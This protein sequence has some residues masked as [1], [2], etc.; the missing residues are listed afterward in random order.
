MGFRDGLKE[1]LSKTSRNVPPEQPP[2]GGTMATGEPAA[3]GEHSSSDRDLIL[4]LT[5]SLQE[6]DVARKLA[7]AESRNMASA[8]RKS[9]IDSVM[10]DGRQHA[11]SYKL[12]E[13]NCL[14]YDDIIPDGFYDVWGDFADVVPTGG[15]FPSLHDLRGIPRIT[16]DPREVLL[17]DHSADPGLCTAAERL[18]ERLS[19][20][21]SVTDKI[22][23][24]VSWVC[25]GGDNDDHVPC[26]YMYNHTR[27]QAIAEV[28]SSALGGS[29]STTKELYKQWEQ[30]SRDVK[31]RHRGIVVPLGELS[32]GLYRHRALLFKVLAD[33]IELPCR[34]VR[35][36]HNVPPGGVLKA[37]ALV[38]VDGREMMVDLLRSPGRIVAFAVN[39]LTKLLGVICIAV[40]LMPA[41]LCFLSTHVLH[42]VCFYTPHSPP[43]QL[44]H[45]TRVQIRST[46]PAPL[47]H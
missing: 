41:L 45:P 27:T 17:V 34:L 36:V 10:G 4:A 15:S 1:L 35:A 29:A 3:E 12:W 38:Q 40:F 46:A 32:V 20:N 42:C 26:A 43:P 14:E 21:S 5:M 44:H 31:K 16:D 9:I 39:D 11:L 28:V 47:Q 22:R 8:K 13:D 23:V 33:S 30:A 2:A 25:G 6:R 19:E 37:A 18:T 7:N 24:C